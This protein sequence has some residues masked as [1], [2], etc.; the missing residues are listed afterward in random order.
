MC[1]KL[2][3]FMCTLGKNGILRQPFLYLITI[4][5]VLTGCSGN[6]SNSLKEEQKKNVGVAMTQIDW[7]STWT[8]RKGKRKLVED[9]AREYEILNQNI[10]INLKFTQELWKNVNSAEQPFQHILSMIQSGKTDWDIVNLDKQTYTNISASLKDDKWTA[11]YLV[12][13]EEFDWFRESHKSSV[14]NDSKY[15][16][17]WGG[18]LPGPLIE[19]YYHAFWY[20]KKVAERIGLHIKPM[21]MTFDDLVGYISK[22]YEYNKTA[23]QKVILLLE[24]TPSKIK[25]DLLNS[26]IISALGNIDTSKIDRVHNLAALK[27]ALLAM[28]KLARYKPLDMV[29]SINKDVDPLLDEKALFGIFPSTTYNIWEATDKEKIKNVVPVELPVFETPGIFYIGSYQSVWAVFKNAPHREE[30][31]R[32]IRFMCSNDIAERWVSNTKNPTALNVRIDASAFGQ[33]EIEK[34][35]KEIERKYQGKLTIYNISKILFGSQSSV[36]IDGLPILRG[37]ISADNYYD[38]V[39]KESRKKK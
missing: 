36:T 10:K 14:I 26:L 11:K 23:A 38:Q 32:L 18:I 35:N 4:F 25:T 12:N 31:I 19:G 24:A 1:R 2:G 17:S 8:F 16:Q 28:E 22:A 3:C 33:D 7:M 29:T 30:A 9:A 20:N 5:I 27:R 34:F 15:R 13:F 37:D 39:L 21:G 6:S